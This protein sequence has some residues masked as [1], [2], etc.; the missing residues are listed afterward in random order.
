MLTGLKDSAM[1]LAAKAYLNDKFSDYGEVLECEIDTAASRIS[2]RAQ[3]RGESVPVS[4]GVERYEIRKDSQGAFIVLHELSG[5]REWLTT[6]LNSLF[7]GKRYAIPS[8][9]GALL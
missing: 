3:L 7:A 9:I 5:S 1:S 4:A 8:T 6:L 2:I